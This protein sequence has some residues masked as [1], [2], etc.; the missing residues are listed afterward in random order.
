LAE[1]SGVLNGEPDTFCIVDSDYFRGDSIYMN[2]PEVLLS[3][4][5]T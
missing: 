2:A 5:I 3:A 1:T 4:D